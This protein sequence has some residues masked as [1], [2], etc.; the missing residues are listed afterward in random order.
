MVFPVVR[1]SMLKILAPVLEPIPSCPAKKTQADRHIW[2]LHVSR[3]MSDT[4]VRTCL[5]QCVGFLNGTLLG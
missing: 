3:R 5:S 4:F 2:M 1:R